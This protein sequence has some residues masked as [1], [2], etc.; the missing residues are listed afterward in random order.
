MLLQA[1]QSHFW[2]NPRLKYWIDLLVTRGEVTASS[3][4][5]QVVGQTVPLRTE[6]ASCCI[7]EGYCLRVCWVQ[8]GGNS[9]SEPALSLRLRTPA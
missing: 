4:A 2:S 8:T 3:P 7:L 1:L 9:Y 5:A 6:R